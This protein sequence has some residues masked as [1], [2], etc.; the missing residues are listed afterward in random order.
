MSRAG[1][2]YG[3]ALMESFYETFKAE[4]IRQNKFTNDELLNEAVTEY[5]YVW[6]NHVHLHSSNCY[7]TP[8]EKRN[9][10]TNKP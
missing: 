3:N 9:S 5:S 7:M 8:L 10:N 2:P 6:Y 1:C 4:L